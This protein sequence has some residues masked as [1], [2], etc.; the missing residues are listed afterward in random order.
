M[1]HAS[2]VRSCGV[3][4]AKP[5]EAEKV[6]SG[7]YNGVGWYRSLPADRQWTLPDRAALG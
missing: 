5:S 6:V 1:V 2:C 4:I 7:G 3:T